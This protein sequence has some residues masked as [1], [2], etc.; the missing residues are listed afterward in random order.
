M[1][2]ILFTRPI[3]CLVSKSAVS[4]NTKHIKMILLFAISTTHYHGVRQLLSYVYGLY[5]AW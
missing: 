3:N 1:Q 4:P 2:C 5:N